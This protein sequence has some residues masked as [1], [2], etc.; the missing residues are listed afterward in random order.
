M[1]D[2]SVLIPT[3]NRRA[4]LAVTLTS[5]CFQETNNF[6]V[7]IADQSEQDCRDGKAPLL[8][9]I[10]LLEARGVRVRIERNLPRRG[11]AQ[12]RQFLLDRARAPYSLFI[13]DDLVLEPYVIRMLRD[14]L[15][16]ENC[17][18]AGNAVIGLSYVDD[19]RPAEQHIELWRGPVTPETVTPG[20]PEWQRHTL[21]NA[22]NLWHVQRRL[23]ASPASP[24]LYKVAWVGGCVMYDTGKLRDAG[25]FDF[26]KDLPH[27]H[28]GEDVLAQLRVAARFGAC[29]VLP[30]G[31][32][33]QELETTVPDRRVNAPEY[34]RV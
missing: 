2:V 18:F 32:Y 10:R 28:C 11:M 23:H 9:T 25:G 14:V 15:R 19:V 31:A 29:G 17:G 27:S 21:H 22:A 24:V 1:A 5:L 4:A 7:V 13:D 34:L 3:Y 26:W 20:G 6:D 33:H 16:R 30:S 12:Q 8:T